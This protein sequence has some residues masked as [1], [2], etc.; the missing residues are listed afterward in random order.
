MTCMSMGY[1]DLQ[2]E[3]EIAQGKT[4]TK[5]EDLQPVLLPEQLWEM[6]QYEEQI[7]VHDHV[8]KYIV[9]LME[10][11]RK[12]AY[13]ELGVSPRGTIACVR[14]AKAWAFLQGRNYVI[15]DD[16]T[17]IFA[18]VA[19]HRIVLNTKARIG[20]VT[21]DATLQEILSDVDKPTTYKRLRG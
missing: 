8:A 14:L 21:V 12:N 7:Y 1:P 3:M 18:D 2:S 13:I 16:V 10:A 20:H 15:P 4:M 11:T 9:Q 6:Q 5:A 19:K 17:D